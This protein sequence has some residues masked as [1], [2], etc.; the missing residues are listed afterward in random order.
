MSKI[1]ET[2]DGLVEKS[3]GKKIVIPLDTTLKSTHIYLS[4]K[5]FCPS[6]EK[7]VDLNM[8]AGCKYYNRHSINKGD[9]GLPVFYAI[10]LFS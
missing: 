8:Y 3:S 9:E 5:C 2:K 6:Q 1:T 10:C 7:E 4:G